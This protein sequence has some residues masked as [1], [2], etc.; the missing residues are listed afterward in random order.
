MVV[1]TECN[2]SWADYIREITHKANGV[3]AITQ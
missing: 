1:M 2:L 3:Y